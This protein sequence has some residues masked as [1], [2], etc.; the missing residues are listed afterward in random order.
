[1]LELNFVVD[2]NYLLG[3]IIASGIDPDVNQEDLTALG[4]KLPPAYDASSRDRQLLNPEL[5]DF[6]RSVTL[7]PLILL[8]SSLENFPDKVQDLAWRLKNEEE[9]HRIITQTHDYQRKIKEQWSSNLDTTLEMMQDITGLDFDDQF[10]VYVVHPSL[11]LALHM[12]EK[13]IT[14]GYNEEF[15]NITIIHLYH[16]IMHDKL[17]LTNTAHAVIELIDNELRVRMNGGQYPPFHGYDEHHHIMDY[18]LS[19]WK[20]YLASPRKNI[21][22]FVREITGEDAWFD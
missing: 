12:P 10:T 4:K 3:N 17:P 20:E 18:Y 15:P 19:E 21:L 6:Y 7:N 2:Q 1:M 5:A 13:R 22:E 8:D 16:E 11:N 9:F 14:Y